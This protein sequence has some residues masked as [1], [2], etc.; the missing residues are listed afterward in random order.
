M[1]TKVKFDL[2]TVALDDSFQAFWQSRRAKNVSQAT[3]NF[4]QATVSPF[5]SWL[6]ENGVCNPGEITTQWVDNYLSSVR[7]RNVSDNTLNAHARAVRTVLIFL[8][9][10]EFIQKRVKVQMP[11][12]GDV[13]HQTLSTEEIQTVLE[14][15]LNPRDQAIISFMLDTGARRQEVANLIWEDV[16]MG[17]G[18]VHI[19]RGKGRKSRW[20]GISPVTIKYLVA[21]RRARN[22]NLSPESQ[23]FLTDDNKPM[24]GE[25]LRQIFERISR[26]AGFHIHPHALRHTYATNANADGMSLHDIQLTMGHAESTTTERYIQ[27]LPS[28]IVE[29]QIEHSLMMKI[30]HRKKR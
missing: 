13:T 18:S 9:E 25:T 7:D 8:L 10:N 15:C 16:N 20:V 6:K 2:A 5:F 19:I 24:N 4:Y 12:I 23:V 14:V 27:T 17:T 11:K 26:R 21:Y 22:A 3:L 29:R 1:E 28:Q 30:G